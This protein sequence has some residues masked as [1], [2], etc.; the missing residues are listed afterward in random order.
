MK[1]KMKKT[2]LLFVAVL[3]TSA[4]WA[5]QSQTIRGFVID[6]ASRAPLQ[7]ANVVLSGSTPLIY[8]ITDSEGN[9]RLEKV[10]LGRQIL[11]VSFMGY[12]STTL[13]PLIVNS[14]KENVVEVEL[15][16]YAFEGSEII[17]FGTSKDRPKN[18]MALI[19]ARSF[20][21]E[22]T[23]KYAG[24]RGDVARMAMN[25]A[26]VSA[27]NDQRND[28]IIRGN[29]PAGLLWKLE[30]VDIPNPNHFAETGTTGGPVGML[31]N[32]LLENSDFFTGAF[33]SEYGNALSGV[34]DLKM[35]NGNNQ[36]YEHLFQVGFNG[37]E[38]QTEGPFSVEKKSSYLAN[39]RYST[40]QLMDNIIDFGTT[41]IPEYKDMSFKMNFPSKKGRVT[42]FGLGG[43]SRI[44]M[45][46][47]KDGNEQDLYSDEGQDLVNRSKMGVIGAS[48]TRFIDD[49]TWYK[50]TFSG[51]YQN[52]GTTIDTLDLDNIPHPNI[53]HNYA[54]YKISA[55][56]FLHRKFNSKLSGRVG[57]SLDRIGFS[58]YTEI[59]D[60]DEN[61]LLTEIDYGKNIFDGVTLFQPYLQGI[62]KFS[63]K[64]SVSPGIHFSYFGLNNSTS[65]EPR[66]SFNW[67]ISSTQK[68]NIGYGLHSKNQSLSTY[69]IGTHMSDGS[70]AETNTKLE[71]TKSHQFVLGYEKAISQ[72]I[73]FKAE[74]YYQYI[75]NAP[76]EETA[77]SFSMLNTGASWGVSAQ[78]SLQNKGQGANYGV[79]CTL[80]KFFSNNIYYLA[81]LSLFESK[82][83]G[84]DGILRSTAFN[85]N[86]VA[87]VLLGKEILLKKRSSLNIDLK[88]SVAGGKRYSPIDIEASQLERTT[89]YI[90][91]EAFSKQFS[92]FVKAD[93]KIG[94]KRNGK[95][96]SQEWVFYV[97]N[98]TNHKNI[99]MQ[100]Y[101]KSENRVKNIYQLGVFP[102]MQ[103]RLNF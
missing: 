52:G 17:V 90:E 64:L 6:K 37:F 85:G 19:S 56:S 63:E 87:N 61:K 22:E 40:M 102:M 33:P 60:K 3:I 86:Y 94:Y 42:I 96:M 100:T 4:L 24:S 72:N 75:F 82:Y 46:D 92:P 91:T 73:R 2:F 101:S 54:E 83:K 66:V 20:S 26:G 38:L 25:F 70:L 58:F 55:N 21:V 28:I 81:T 34:F 32:N 36:K 47:S 76:V 98:F 53:D 99:L 84:S 9:F 89:K 14:A 49:H 45:L 62:Y 59:Y 1:N 29:S 57:M 39:F 44:A 50:L 67:Q 13:E 16:E 79:E 51:V 41:G 35:R 11:I 68:M 77:S 48:Y 78:D 10:P 43:D 88:A 23:E 103:Y 95:K 30:D 93:F 5:Q 71:M 31:N 80:E 69:F 18:Q 8:S 74:A 12:K 15:E 27:A 97:E 7:G 65:L